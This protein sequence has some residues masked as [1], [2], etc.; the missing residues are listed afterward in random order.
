MVS[1]NKIYDF[2]QR[3]GREF[4]PEKVILFGSYV[5]GNATADSDVDFLV[6]S[7]FEGS[8]VDKSVEIRMQLRPD[9]PMDLLVKS[10]DM[11]KR[12]L[13]LEDSFIKEILEKGKVIYEAD[14]N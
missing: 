7:N 14:D 6:I 3:I 10:P 4:K 13:E 11:I 5:T 12:R 1:L 8:S 2:G 9:F